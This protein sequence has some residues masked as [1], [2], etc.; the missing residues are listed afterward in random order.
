MHRL[1]WLYES[2]CPG[3]HQARLELVDE[4]RIGVAVVRLRVHLVHAQAGGLRR[5]VNGKWISMFRSA[6]VSTFSE[7]AQ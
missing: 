7:L 6:S 1:A 3:L 5:I 4:V 2:S